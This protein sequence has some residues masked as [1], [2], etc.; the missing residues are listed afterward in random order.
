M[1][2]NGTRVDD[3]AKMEKAMESLKVRLLNTK[4][5]DWLVKGMTGSLW[6]DKDGFKRFVPDN[7]P[8]D[9]GFDETGAYLGDCLFE[10]LEDEPRC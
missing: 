8:D 4:H 3:A 7:P 9:Y 1:L 6:A 2:P 5:D 10:I